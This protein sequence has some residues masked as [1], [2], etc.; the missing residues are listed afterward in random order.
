MSSYKQNYKF[1]SKVFVLIVHS[2]V[3]SPTE[4]SADV[5]EPVELAEDETD[6]GRENVRGGV[7]KEGGLEISRARIYENT[8]W[9]T[10]ARRGYSIMSGIMTD[11]QCNLWRSLHNKK[12]S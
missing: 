3:I 4:M 12:I 6:V 8:P 11:G 9:R 10:A 7:K 1:V 5:M 2:F